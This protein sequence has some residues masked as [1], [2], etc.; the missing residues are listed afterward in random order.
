MYSPALT[1]TVRERQQQYIDSANDVTLA[2][3]EGWSLSRRLWNN[4]IAMLGP[5]L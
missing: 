3:V 1:Q 4:S 2:E 5:V